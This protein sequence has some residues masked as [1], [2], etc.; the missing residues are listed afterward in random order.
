[1]GFDPPVCIEN[2]FIGMDKENNAPILNQN[3]DN[4]QAARLQP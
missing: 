1:M 4:I 3:I 2:K